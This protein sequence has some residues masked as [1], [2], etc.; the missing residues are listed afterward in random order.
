M[1]IDKKLYITLLINTRTLPEYHIST[2]HT[3]K[4]LVVLLIYKK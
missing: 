3:H 4:T 2:V 1:V